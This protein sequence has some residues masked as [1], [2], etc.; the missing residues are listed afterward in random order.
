MKHLRFLAIL[1]AILALG[2][3]GQ[4]AEATLIDWKSLPKDPAVLATPEATAIADNILAYQ[5]KSGGWPKNIAMEK[6]L[7]DADRA[8]LAARDESHPTSENAPTIDNGSTT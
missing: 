5:Y 8:A 6:P 3:I 2:I 1:P 7:T 4:A